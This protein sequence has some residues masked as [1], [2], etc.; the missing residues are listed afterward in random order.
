LYDLIP[1]IREPRARRPIGEWNRGM[2]I[3]YP[4]GKVE[5]YLNSWKMLEYQR[6]SQYYYALVAK[7]KYEKWPDFGMAATGHILIQDHGNTVSYR[8]IKIQELK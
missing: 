1:S 2:I 3:V 5:H 6:G 7:S 4:D 8:S